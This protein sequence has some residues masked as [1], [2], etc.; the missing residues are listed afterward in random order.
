MTLRSRP[1]LDRKHR[2]RW[3]DELRTQQLTIIGF[4]L[5]IAIALGIFG[6]AAWNGYWESHLRP[7]ASVAGQT[8]TRGDLDARERVI[9]AET[10]A[11]INELSGQV[12]VGPRDQVLQQQVQALSDRLGSIS[13]AASE[14]L[15]EGATLEAR[16]ATFGVA[17]TEDEVDAEIAARASL[18]ERVRARLVLIEALPED[19]EEDAE[20][21]DEQLAAA[22]ESAQEAIDRIEGGE[23]FSAVAIDVSDDFTAPTGGELG[24]FEDGDTAYDAYFDALADADAGDLVGPVETGRGFAVLELV[25][26]RDATTEGGV[27]EFLDA[28]GVPDA[29]YRDHVRQSLL[30]DAFRDHFAEQVVVT[31]TAQRRVAE[32]VIRPPTGEVVPQERA[33]HVLVQ[34]DPELDSQEEATEEQWET[35][36]AEAEE[37]VELVGADDADWF[38]IAEEHSDDTGSGARGGDLGWYDPE[39]SPFVEPFTEALADL[40]VGE[41]SEPIRTDFG[42]HV[43]QKTGERES[44]QEQAADLVQ[45]LREDPDTFAET[46]SVISENPETAREGGEVGWIAPYQLDEAREEAV[47]A[48]TEVGEVSDP[49]DDPTIGLTIYQLLETSESREIE[50]DRLTEIRTTGFERWMDDEVR[51]GVDTWL[52]P[53]FTSATT[54]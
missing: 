10:V 21:T 52:D 32:I 30:L 11:E 38:E 45:Q 27:T 28:Q 18:P 51:T 9:T 29:A 17:V 14:A 54:G 36:L 50:E 5:A 53:Q 40:E 35:A 48:L 46:A 37:V 13:T 19:A 6:A 8:F 39:A 44:P 20:P 25:D 3:Q 15:V 24:W 43:I 26:R 1:V 16:A 23:D 7:V 2:P 22:R 33:R 41:I 31:P 34:P 12:G 42:W 4:A 47:F 49:V